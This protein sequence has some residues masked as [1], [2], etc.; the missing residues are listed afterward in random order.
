MTTLACLGTGKI[1][2]EVAFLATLTDFVDELILY[3]TY[4]PVLTAQK[5]D[6]LHT[7]DI[8]ISTDIREVKSADFCVFS[9]GFPRTPEIKTRA[10]LFDANLPV[11]KEAALHLKNFDGH[12][13]VVT[14]PMDAF[15]WYFAKKSGL[16]EDQVLGF[17][18]L[19]DSRRFELSL[20]TRGFASKNAFILGEHG[21][22]Q[23]PIFSRLSEKILENIREEILTELRGSSM[24]VIKGKGGTV[25]GPAYHILEMMKDIKDDRRRLI[26]A[27]VPANGA[28]E[29][30]NCSIGLPIQLGKNFR[31]DESWKLDA[32]EKEKLS[33]AAA[34]L[35]SLC[36]RV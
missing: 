35:T 20:E 26:T 16:N 36:G 22:H 4:E 9:A 5:L 34:H 24:P 15:T 11:A 28:Y 3:D 31:I 12:V 2:G 10:D 29:I 17:G 30:E 14:N 33:A 8:A 19:L 6:I 21:E 13:I 23:V 27:S 18:G 32:W 1:G 25:F 7:K